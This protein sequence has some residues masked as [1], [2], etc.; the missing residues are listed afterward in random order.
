MPTDILDKARVFL[1][2]LNQAQKWILG[3]VAGVVL[4]GII[5]IIVT[6]TEPVETTTLFNNLEVTDASSIIDYLKANKI[7]YDIA[8]GGSTIIVPKKGVIELRMAIFNQGLIQ[9]STVGYELFDKTN[10][11]MSEQVQKLNSRRALEGEL[12]RMIKSSDEIRDVKVHLVIPD[13]TLFKQQEK[14]PSAAVK[15]RFKNGRSYTKVS[16]EGIQNL[17]ASSVEGMSVDKVVVTDNNNKVLSA[18]PVDESSLAGLT[19]S[20]L[21]QQKKV[22]NYL[23]DKV[24]T[25]LEPAFGSENSKVR[26][27]TEID[28]DQLQVNTTDYNPERQVERSEQTISDRFS[29]I[30]TSFVPGIDE[31]QEKLNEIRNYEITKAD[32]HYVK[33]IGSIKRLTVTAIINEVVEVRKLPNGLD[34]VVSLPRSQE[35][36]NRYTEAIK[37]VVGF[38]ERRGDQVNVLCVPFVELLADKITEV[39]ERNIINSTQW[40]QKEDNQKLILLLLALLITAITMYRLIHAKFVRDK[41][42]IAMGLPV[43]LEAPKL[44]KFDS[45]LLAFPEEEEE[46]DYEEDYEEEEE[47]VEE[48]VVEEVPE[49]EEEEEEE[50]L[51]LHLLDDAVL[52]DEMEGGEEEL[53]VEEVDLEEDEIMTIPDELPEQLFLDS[54]LLDEFELDIISTL[55]EEIEAQGE[56][57]ESLLDRARAALAVPEQAP[58]EMSEDDLIKIELR[59]R[60]TSFILEN[61]DVAVKLFRIFLHQDDPK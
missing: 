11:G 10:L 61:T 37:T 6:N 39:N 35:E 2:K 31:R 44:D 3:G 28:F 41:M 49:E 8:D 30:D 20:Q 55:D 34:T 33:G 43:K 59:E 17:V 60:V 47:V 50:E 48:E 1:E 23:T 45:S 27:N 58:S 24:Q 18:P 4:A 14:Q 5:A 21:E 25:L 42:R 29:N 51:D 12:Q 57:S 52:E 16:I 36:L 26:L 56:E 19:A 46:D 53:E 38:N 54:K 7:K 9:E 22:E 40:Y 15:L 13:K 32:S